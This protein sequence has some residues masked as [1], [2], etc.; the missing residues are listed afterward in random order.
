VPCAK[1]A[2]MGAIPGELD[3]NQTW[4]FCW[5]DGDNGWG[6]NNLISPCHDSELIKQA[7]APSPAGTLPP[8]IRNMTT[9]NGEKIYGYLVPDIRRSAENTSE[10]AY[11]HTICQSVQLTK[12]KNAWDS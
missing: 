3:N 9:A 11:S 8:P 10:I 1:L 2:E 7:T 6:F 12:R 4:D 5:K